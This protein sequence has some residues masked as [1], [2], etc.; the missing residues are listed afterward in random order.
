VNPN[1][2][3]RWWKV[4]AFTGLVL[5]VLALAL[6][7]A[8]Y[9]LTPLL[10]QRLSAVARARFGSELH[11]QTLTVSLF[12]HVTVNATGV[13]FRQSG[14]T[15]VPPL[16]TIDRV[17]V[18]AGIA[19]LIGPY[20]R[21]RRMVFQKL[22]ITVPPRDPN[23][24]RMR[25]SQSHTG[26]RFIADELIAD[27]TVLTILPSQ[28]GKEPLV[29]DVHKLDLHPGGQAAMHYKADMTNAKPPGLIHAE[30]DFGPWLNEDPGGTPL[31]GQYTFTNAD[32]SVFK[33]IS[34]ILSSTGHFAGDLQTINADG[35]T[36]TPDFALRDANHPVHLTA[37]FHA[38]ING[39]DGETLLQPVTAQ[40][41]HTSIVCRGGVVQEGGEKAKTV[42]LDGTVQNG[43]LEDVLYLATQ[44]KQ[45]MVGV[46]SFNSKIV[47]PPGNIDVVK[48][49]QLDGHATV[50][51]VRFTNPQVQQKVNEVSERAQG[52]PKADPTQN[53][54]STLNARFSMKNGTIQFS[55]LSFAL[56][57]AQLTLAGSYGI[58]TE[59]LDFTGHAR[60][61]A[62]LSEMTTGVKHVLLKAAD[63]FFKKDGA[64]AE[65]PV[66]ISGTREHPVFGL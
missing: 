4:L 24:A 14:R 55:A 11:F 43:R 59:G 37:Q 27:E 17:N 12:P 10:S 23:G 52:H 60:T 29:F 19:D 47:I 46:L 54:F 7:T 33:G 6:D 25:V 50:L 34:G 8:N 38:V 53:V 30:G 42:D 63:P 28:P 58:L 41:L 5:G 51:K 66:H 15:D 56:P 21:A 61:D 20:R 36:D 44:S 16:F 2:H 35:T 64:G 49:L 3:S 31:N 48:K 9:W 40:F 22:R 13:S 18:E 32:L 26:D 39:I 65:L 62:K 1:P 45:P 57:G